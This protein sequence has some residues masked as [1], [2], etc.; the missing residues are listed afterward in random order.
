MLKYLNK[1]STFLTRRKPGLE[2]APSVIILII[3]ISVD[4]HQ[5]FDQKILSW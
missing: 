4:C 1:V 2:Q 3:I 5:E